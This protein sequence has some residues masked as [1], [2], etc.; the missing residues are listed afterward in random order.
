MG[1]AMVRLND[2]LKTAEAARLLG[3]S[4]NTLRHG[5]A[6]HLL[7]AEYGIRTVQEFLGHASVETTMIDCHVLDRGGAGVVCP[8][9]G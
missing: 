5:F 4:Q 7:E 8:L 2:H 6:T 9:D 3:V 1:R